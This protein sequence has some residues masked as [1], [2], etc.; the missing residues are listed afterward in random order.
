MAIVALAHPPLPY[1]RQSYT[2]NN[3]ISSSSRPNITVCKCNHTRLGG[4][5]P[6]A[7][8]QPSAAMAMAHSQSDKDRKICD[9]RHLQDQAVGR[10]PAMWLSCESRRRRYGVIDHSRKIPECWLRRRQRRCEQPGKLSE[11]QG[12][13]ELPP[14]DLRV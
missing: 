14:A 3:S 9:V 10:R 6:K 4:P 8:S 1:F 11:V 13:A 12:Q 7:P 2:P 5:R